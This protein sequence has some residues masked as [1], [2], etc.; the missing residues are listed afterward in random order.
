LP[1]EAWISVEADVA[2]LNDPHALKADMVDGAIGE[3]SQFHQEYAYYGQG[4]EVSTAILPDGWRN[5]LV[6]FVSES[7]EPASALCLDPH[8]LVVSKLAA[9][10]EKDFAFS[11]AL[12]KAGL[13]DP[14]TLLER[15][16]M[17][18][19]PHGMHRAA[20]IYWLHD[21]GTKARRRR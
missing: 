17:L 9:R 18:P 13:V 19:D 12:I 7:A 5:R 2:F 10:R 20:V 15:A 3:L 14:D 6:G 4:V 16:A 21:T 1:K 11:L 8:D